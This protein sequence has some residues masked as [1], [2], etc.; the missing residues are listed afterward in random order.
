MTDYKYSLQGAIVPNE[1]SQLLAS[2]Y[3]IL[4]QVANRHANSGILLNQSLSDL[5]ASPIDTPQDEF[6]D[7]RFRCGGDL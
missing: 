3:R 4:L 5:V 1:R 6:G 2:A 7:S